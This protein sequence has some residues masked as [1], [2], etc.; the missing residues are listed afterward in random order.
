MLTL[1]VNLL[2]TASSAQRG[3]GGVRGEGWATCQAAREKWSK[4]QEDP[5]ISLFL[6]LSEHIDVTILSTKNSS[7]FPQETVFRYLKKRIEKW[8]LITLKCLA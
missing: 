2:D 4:K 3:G 7:M 8:K 5:M 6:K 1:G